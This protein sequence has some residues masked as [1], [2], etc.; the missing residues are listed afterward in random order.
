MKNINDTKTASFWML[1]LGLVAAI[2]RGFAYMLAVDEK[3]LLVRFH[4]CSVV[5]GILC[6]AALILALAQLKG[7]KSSGKW[8]DTFPSGKTSA[9]G[10]LA[11]AVGIGL[12]VASGND[13]ARGNLAALWNVSGVLSALGLVWAALSRMK[14]QK[15]FLPIYAVVCLFLALHMVSRY[16][17]WSGDPQ[18]MDWIFSL[19]GAVGLTLCAYHLAAFAV[20]AGHRRTFRTVGMLTVFSC[21]ATLLHTDY[22][23][24]Y[25]GGLVWVFTALWD[26]AP[27]G[28]GE[29]G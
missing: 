21:G 23:W 10:C 9:L 17:P 5:L 15:P 27:A 25:L 18:V 3:G 12:T 24:L 7:K 29:E 16:Q 6:A 2:A 20:D 28:K 11:M 26:M 22:L 19:F 13:P 8:E 1:L 4:P 14:G